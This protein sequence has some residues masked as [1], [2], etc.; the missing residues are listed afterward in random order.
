MLSEKLTSLSKIDKESLKAPSD[1]SAIKNNASSS[2]FMFS[3]LA[4]YLKF[5]TISSLLTLLKSKIWHRDKIVG[6]ILCFSVVA[7]INLACGGGSSKVFKKALNADLD[8]ICTSSIMYTLYFPTWGGTLTWSVKFL[9]SSTELFEAAS[10]SNILNEKSS[11]SVLLDKLISLAKIL[12]HVVLPTPLGPQKR[13]DWANW[14]DL[15]AFFKVDVTEDWPTT[16]SNVV[17]R[18]FLADTKNS[19]IKN[20]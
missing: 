7:K 17:G 13:K 12:A 5:F 1:F 4:T 6:I 15:I 9:I 10:N 20:Y 11:I 18:Y 16:P 14:F 2:T 8:N 3:L 19:L